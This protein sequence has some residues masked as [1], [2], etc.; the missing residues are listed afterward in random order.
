MEGKERLARPQTSED[1][2]DLAAEVCS[3]LQRAYRA[4]RFY[5]PDHPLAGEALDRLAAC[6]ETALEDRK[7]LHLG[8]GETSFVFE[9]EEVYRSEDLREGIPFLL[10]RDGVRRLSFLPG[11]NRDE[12]LGLVE[13]LVKAQEVDKSEHDVIT[14]L[15]ERDF[16]HI[17]Y[18]VVDPLLEGE[19]EGQDEVRRL[20]DQIGERVQAAADSNITRTVRPDHVTANPADRGRAEGENQIELVGTMVS[21]TE[22]TQLEA[23]LE[24][25]KDVLEEFGVV[26]LEV[27]AN[28][29]EEDEIRQA[30]AALRDLTESYL[31]WGD[32]EQLTALINHL[33]HVRNEVGS[34]KP[35]LEPVIATFED[36]ERLRRAIFALDGPNGARLTGVEQF[37]MSIREWAYPV[38][39][40]LLVEASGKQ[41]RKCLLNVLIAGEGVPVR[42]ILPRLRDPRWYVVR[43]MV[44]L[45]GRLKN[46]STL[47]NLEP[48][49]NHPDDRV[50]K[51]VIRALA[52]LGDP[53]GLRAVSSALDDPS[54]SVRIVAARH[55]GAA[56]AR[57][58]LPRLL[59]Q[60]ASKDF[61]TRAEGE[62]DA[63]LEAVGRIGSDDAVPALNDLWASRSL[64]RSKPTHVRLLALRALGEIGTPLARESLARAARDSNEAVRRQAKRSLW[65]AERQASQR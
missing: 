7:P 61:A 38:L 13:V 47:Q 24:Q 19:A 9:E 21:E 57:P 41:S 45:L 35:L 23:T 17:D 43:N 49:L 27:V 42:L 8:V 32:F 20:T 22:L 62:V 44:Y 51:E 40:D 50:R 36:I 55:L 26:L 15:W 5:P 10:F 56:K 4:V 59:K 31:E 18:T 53:R 48:V 64:F 6:L 1:P 12:I 52:L 14:M 3:L 11:L 2:R 34:R 65:E 46:P 16:A 25:E 29:K 33:K 39:V 60:I 63:F 30:V 37:L 54:S 28:A 58:A